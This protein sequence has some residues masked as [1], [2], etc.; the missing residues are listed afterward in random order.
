LEAV[1]SHNTLNMNGKTFVLIP[2]QEYARIMRHADSNVHPPLP[3]TDAEGNFPAFEAALVTMAH[4]IIDGRIAVGMTQRA[5]ADAAGIR[6]ETLNRIEK[7]KSNPDTATI[8]KIDRAL[9]KANKALKST[10]NVKHKIK[11]A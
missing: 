11:K 10:S 1:M 6:P 5:L 9:K 8:A 2:E 4:T 7:G 3:P